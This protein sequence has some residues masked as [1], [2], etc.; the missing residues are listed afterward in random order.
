MHTRTIVAVTALWLGACDEGTEAAREQDAGERL[1]AAVLDA[2][3][4]SDARS[5]DA[6]VQDAMTA[7]DAGGSEADAALLDD[8]IRHYELDWLEGGDGGYVTRASIEIDASVEKVWQLVRDVNGYERWCSVLRAQ[9]ASVAPGQPIRL[10]IQLGDPASSAPTESD[11]VIGVVD[12]TRHA[13]S[14]QRDF[15]LGQQTLRFQVVTPSPGGARYSTALRYPGEL[16]SLVIPLLGSDL[17][18]AFRTIAE[19]LARA[20]AR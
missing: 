20:A 18:R 6:W 3:R 4:A 7:R 10:A 12:D 11:E 2:A 14:W 13:I 8:A 1:D 19:D 9:A 17:D 16:G 15:G 5:S